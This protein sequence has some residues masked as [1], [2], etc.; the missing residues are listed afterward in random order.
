LLC[1]RPLATRITL[2]HQGCYVRKSYRDA[3]LAIGAVTI[4]K[5][6]CRIC[7]VPGKQASRRSVIT[8]HSD[9]SD[10]ECGGRLDHPNAAVSCN[11][12]VAAPVVD[13]LKGRLVTGANFD[14]LRDPFVGGLALQ[15]QCS[16]PGIPPL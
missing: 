15:R 16:L 12:G 4:V 11:A 7:K 1:F 6:D 8:G 2:A 10:R 14:G 13:E 5:I 9:H 3:M